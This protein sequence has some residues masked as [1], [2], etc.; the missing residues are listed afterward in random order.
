MSYLLRHRPD[1]VGLKLDE[2]GWLDVDTLLE[3]LK[4][5]GASVTRP[6]LEEV[7]ETS[8]KR[9]FAFSDDGSR[10]RASQGHSVDVDLKL[11]P[12][13]PPERLYHGTVER[14]LPSIRTEGLV[15]QGRHHVHLSPDE[16][17]AQV[18]GARRGKAIVLVVD[19]ARM[20]TVG[21]AFYCS[22]N[23]VWLTD[24]V[25]PEFLSE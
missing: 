11:K 4:K 12:Q 1:E 14:S 18:V 19:A 20:R 22:D 21:H 5:S 24:W 2:G 15:P 13:S 25:P 23:G 9:R 3:A 16:V 7:V 6:P 10:I 8:D 17:T